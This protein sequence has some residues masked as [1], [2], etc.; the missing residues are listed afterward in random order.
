MKI[1]V[2]QKLK[3][4]DGSV[5]KDSDGQGG[6]VDATL[7]D[8]LVNAVL[9]PA[10]KESGIDKVRKYELAKLIF[11]AKT[12]VELT[13]EDVTLLKERVGSVYPA[14]IVGQIFEMLN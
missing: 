2:N 6:A 7:K 8:A 14:L 13:A 5:L 9:A 10:D 11:S 3:N 1:K 12:A 4:L